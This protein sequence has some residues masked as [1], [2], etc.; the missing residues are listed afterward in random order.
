MQRKSTFVQRR[1]FTL[2][3]LLVVIAIISILASI[4]F[5]VFARARENARRASCMSNMKQIALGVMQYTQDHDEMM[6]KLYQRIGGDTTKL[7]WWEDLVQPYVKSYQLFICP[8]QPTPL[9]YD[10]GTRSGLGSGYPVPLLSSYATNAVTDPP[11]GAQVGPFGN[12][13]SSLASIEDPSGTF[14]NVEN[15]GTKEI[16]R[17]E[18]TDLGTSSYIDKRHLDGS[19]Y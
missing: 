19:N 4:L 9:A 6:P 8:S 14:M 7:V 1:A 12:T 13:N 17:Y 16:T 10:G 18:R 3:E 5:P 2:I 11:A 15:R